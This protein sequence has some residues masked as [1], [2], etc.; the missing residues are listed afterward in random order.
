MSEYLSTTSLSR[1]CG[2]QAKPLV[3]S[4][5][6]DNGYLSHDGSSYALTSKGSQYGHLHFGDSGGSWV[7]WD[8]VQLVPILEAYKLRLS[9]IPSADPSHLPRQDNLYALAD[10]YGLDGSSLVFEFL[11]SEGYLRFQDIATHYSLTAKGSKFC[12]IYRDALYEYVVWDSTKLAPVLEGLK[13]TILT[14]SNINFTFY[15]MTHIDNLPAIASKGLFSH[16][17]VA[18]YTDISNISVNNRRQGKEKVFNRTIHSYVPL[19]FNVR[20]AMLYAV[21]SEYSDQ[22]VV[23]E[24][25]SSVCLSNNVLFTYNNAA[26]SNVV[27]YSSLQKFIDSGLWPKIQQRSWGDDKDIKQEMMSECLVLDHIDFGFVKS[28]HCNSSE[29]SQKVSDIIGKFQHNVSVVHSAS[30]LFF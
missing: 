11:A 16:E 7:V 22:V 24:F 29:T 5:L 13:C 21:Q 10:E 9:Q 26:C 8:V 18:G 27:F 4:F 17:S 20:N 28:I 1:L 12:H 3:F 15:H 19:Y 25:A 30:D 14:E 6:L 23:L 2:L